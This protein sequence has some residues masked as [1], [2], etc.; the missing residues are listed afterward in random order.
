MSLKTKALILLAVPTLIWGLTY[1]IGRVALE[2][3]SP[4]A[5]SGLRFL[6]GALSL[7]PLALKQRRRP[8]PLAYTGDHS[9][10]LWLWSGLLVGLILSCGSIMQLYGMTR[11]S[12]GQASFISALYASLVPVLALMFGFVPRLPVIAGIL[13]GFIGLYLLTGGGGAGFGR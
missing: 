3:L 6:F 2:Q 10:R 4:W 13:V 7:A 12:A 11:M 5:F 8:A 1:P 9:P